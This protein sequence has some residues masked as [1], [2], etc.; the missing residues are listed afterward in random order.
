[1][2]VVMYDMGFIFFSECPREITHNTN[3]RNCN[4]ACDG[5]DQETLI[6]WKMEG[7]TFKNLR[8]VIN[9]KKKY[10]KMKRIFIA[11][12]NWRVSLNKRGIWPRGDFESPEVLRRNVTS[13]I[14][15]KMAAGATFHF[16]SRVFRFVLLAYL[17]EI[18][19]CNC[20]IF[21]CERT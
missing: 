15:F 14:K 16:H 11:W 17:N 9:G 13:R 19:K 6:R 4:E 2:T 21:R 5:F 12:R 20:R 10:I 3:K 1:M 7:L 8:A 18:V